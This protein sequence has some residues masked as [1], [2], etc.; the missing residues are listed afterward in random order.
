LVFVAILVGAELGAWVAGTFGGLVGVLLAIPIAAA[1]QVI[2][3]EWWHST[4]PEN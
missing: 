1:L 4:H 3:I 2:A